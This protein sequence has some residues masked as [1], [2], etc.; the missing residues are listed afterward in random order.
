MKT[1]EKK[2]W[3]MMKKREQPMKHDEKD[4]KKMKNDEQGRNKQEALMKNSEKNN[5]TWWKR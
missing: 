5:E 2:Q 3:N 1:S 4:R